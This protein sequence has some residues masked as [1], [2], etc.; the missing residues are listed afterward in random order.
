[1]MKRKY[2]VAMMLPTLVCLGFLTGCAGKDSGAPP[3]T[4]QAKQ[5]TEAEALKKES[6][7]NP[8]SQASPNRDPTG[9]TGDSNRK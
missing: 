1:V 9:E 6:G 2:M 8:Q 7:G 4:P 5:Q 3:V